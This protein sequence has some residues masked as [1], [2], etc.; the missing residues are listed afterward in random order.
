MKRD[1][2]GYHTSH[3]SINES[4]KRPRYRDRYGRDNRDYSYN[5]EVP[6][7]N[8]HYNNM[9]YWYNNISNLNDSLYNTNQLMY[10]NCN[11]LSS[12]YDNID[13]KFYAPFIRTFKPQPYAHYPYKII[14]SIIYGSFNAHGVI[15]RDSYHIYY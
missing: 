8:E 7:N 2:D 6:V 10:A 3:F 11:T 14:N 15:N 13:K 1:R 5:N 9:W 12:N 4:N